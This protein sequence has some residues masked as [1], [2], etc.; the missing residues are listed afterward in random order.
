MTTAIIAMNASALSSAPKEKKPRDRNVPDRG[1]RE[2]YRV[3]FGDVLHPCRH[4][5]EGTSAVLM[6]SSGKV[7]KAP[8]PNT[9]SALFVLR[10]RVERDARP[11]Q[12]EEGDDEQVSRTPGIPDA[13]LNP[14]SVCERDM[15]IDWMVTRNASVASLPRVSPAGSPG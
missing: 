5:A 2:A 11:R 8:I 10:P 6:K 4:G 14:S 3:D 9:V 13:N 12:A 7:R 1:H 15:M